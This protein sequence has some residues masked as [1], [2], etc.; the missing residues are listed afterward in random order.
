MASSVIVVPTNVSD[1]AA[2]LLMIM[3]MNTVMQL[4]HA[5]SG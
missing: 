1:S 2:T 3:I 4:M 5:R